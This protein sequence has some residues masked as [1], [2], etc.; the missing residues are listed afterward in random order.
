MLIKF[1][2]P[3]EHSVLIGDTVFTTSILHDESPYMVVVTA[4]D[5]AVM[6][7]YASEAGVHVFNLS[8][9]P[10]IGDVQSSRSPTEKDIL[11]KKSDEKTFA[12]ELIKT[13]KCTTERI[14][15]PSP[16]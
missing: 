13:Q 9:R 15:A 3:F 10:L 7:W 14:L 8:T 16:V 11:N 1:L 5:V 6:I 12:R 2:T 4:V